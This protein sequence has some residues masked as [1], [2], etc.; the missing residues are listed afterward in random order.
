MKYLVLRIN[1]ER[2]SEICKEIEERAIVNGGLEFPFRHNGQYYEESDAINNL[3]KESTVRTG[4]FHPNCR[5]HL[6]PF[7][8]EN[9]A[10]NEPLD[11]VAE[12]Y[13]VHGV[14]YYVGRFLARRKN[15]MDP[16]SNKHLAIINWEA[17]KNR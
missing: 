11:D 14:G 5:C 1:D 15:K 4:L 7:S 2:S 17:T 12:N 16:I 10:G 13:L 9:T 6:I 8:E 3:G